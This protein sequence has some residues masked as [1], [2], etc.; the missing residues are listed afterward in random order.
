MNKVN[1]Q[2]SRKD[3]LSI[4]LNK[5]KNT[6]VQH[7]NSSFSLYQ[8]NISFIPSLAHHKNTLFKLNINN[9]KYSK[10][11]LT[12]TLLVC[13]NIL[14]YLKIYFYVF[15]LPDRPVHRK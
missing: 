5:K 7:L 13:H 15:I 4:F 3:I 2:I 1:P 12:K 11:K 8:T 14:W 9:K 10:K 6:T